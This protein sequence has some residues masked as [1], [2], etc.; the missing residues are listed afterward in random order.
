MK[1]LKGLIDNTV[2][3]TTETLGDYIAP[4]LKKI[5]HL[6]L[7]L[8][9]GVSLFAGS[10]Q[11]SKADTLSAIIGL[12]TV[13]NLVGNNNNYPSECDGL[14]A[15]PGF[16]QAVGSTN[17]VAPAAA[18]A[19]GAY[20]GNNMGGGNGKT[21]LTIAGAL[22]A[23]GMVSNAQQSALAVK[24]NNFRQLAMA[25]GLIAGN[26][27]QQATNQFGMP[28]TS[29]RAPTRP[30]E[31]ILYK[32]TSDSGNPLY[33]TIEASPGIQAMN[34][35]RSGSIQLNQLDPQVQQAI[36][37]SMES[38]NVKYHNLD[39]V[40][41]S[42]VNMANGNGQYQMAYLTGNSNNNKSLQDKMKDTLKQFETAYVD[43]VSQRGQTALLLDE[44]AVRGLD[45]TP[46]KNY[47]S[48]FQ[49]PQSA[50][51]TYGTAYQKGLDNR[52]PNNLPRAS[53][54]LKY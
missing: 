31:N 10:V 47:S 51:I 41:K 53:N 11:E 17:G 7:G 44:L 48:E 30:G 40:G 1:N 29:P 24:C 6:A 16:Q 21:I 42:Y 12:T 5:P 20:A 4:G 52:Y 22:G 8:A 34:G 27:N 26:G 23:A 49:P 14:Q 25:Q 9:L 50:N 39:E 3:K 45:L 13:G 33:M 46:Y 36:S 43:Y 38:L 32:T 18:A 54:L 37:G 2:A 19:V 28:M 35:M 15:L